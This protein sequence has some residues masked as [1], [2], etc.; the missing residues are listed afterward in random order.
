LRSERVLNAFQTRSERVPEETWKRVP[1]WLKNAFS[2]RKIL[3][4]N[5]T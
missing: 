4:P 3:T 1:V 5:E 2:H